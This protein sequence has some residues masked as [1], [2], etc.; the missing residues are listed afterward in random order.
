MFIT[1]LALLPIVA[2]GTR[3]FCNSGTKHGWNSTK[4]EHQVTVDDVATIVYKGRTAI[5]VTQT[6]DSGYDGRDHSEVSHFQGYKWGDER[7]YGFMFRLSNT[8]DF[9]P[10]SYNIAQFIANRPGAGCGE[11]DWMPSSMLW[12]RGSQ[13]MSR[14]VRGQ[15]RRPDSSR[16]ITDLP[17]LATVSAG[18]WHKVIIQARWKSDNTGFQKIWF[19]GKK[20]NETSDVATTTNDDSTF[21]FRIGLYANGWHDDYHKMVGNQPFRQVWF[22][23]AAIGTEFE[24]VDSDQSSADSWIENDHEMVG[25]QHLP[26]VYCGEAAIGTEPRESFPDQS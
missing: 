12:L 26:Q 3:L 17:N 8:W 14:I 2:K 4:P 16:P 19:D 10:Q 22:D 18:V 9:D 20:V 24:E 7:F 1:T 6:Y 15:Y 13:L 25:N 5:K 23:E 21:E 11:D